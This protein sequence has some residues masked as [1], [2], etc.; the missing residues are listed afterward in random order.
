[1]LCSANGTFRYSW[2]SHKRTWSHQKISPNSLS[3]CLPTHMY[4]KVP[5]KA[6][7]PIAW[8]DLWICSTREVLISCWTDLSS[9]PYRCL[10]LQGRC[11]IP[12]IHY[13]KVAQQVC[14]HDIYLLKHVQ[15][16]HWASSIQWKIPAPT[17]RSWHPQHPNWF[18][19]FRAQ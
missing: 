6:L 16:V 9:S 13:S 4:L 14:R 18:P 19:L 2:T 17:T 3:L 5:F 15:R 11:W 1:M 7:Q 10:L 12:K 8:R